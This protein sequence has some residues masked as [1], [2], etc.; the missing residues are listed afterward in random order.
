MTDEVKV[1][2]AVETVTAAV[3]EA[4]KPKTPQEKN[5]ERQGEKAFS[6]KKVNRFTLAEAQTELKRLEGRCDDTQSRYHDR[7][8]SRIAQLTS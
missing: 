2:K 6:K 5:K 1:E 3:V 8:V 7:I 4:P